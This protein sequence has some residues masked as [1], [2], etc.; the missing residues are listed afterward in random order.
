VDGAKTGGLADANGQ[1]LDAKGGGPGFDYGTPLTW[2]NLVLEPPWPR[3]SH[4]R[5]TKATA[6]EPPPKHAPARAARHR[7]GLLNRSLSPKSSAAQDEIR[8][9]PA[10]RS[11]RLP[12]VENDL[13]ATSPSV[14]DPTGVP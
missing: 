11:S 13:T 12:H 6:I 9:G 10:L 3:T 2:R 4:R 8:S 14:F 7:P 1:L 5:R